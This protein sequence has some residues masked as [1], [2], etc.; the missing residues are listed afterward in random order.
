MNENNKDVET[1]YTNEKLNLFFD[2][3]IDEVSMAKHIRRINYI[4][5]LT[6]IRE[7]ET[8]NPMNKDWLD[9]GFYWLN[10]LAEVLDPNLDID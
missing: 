3:T 2:K 6:T 4:L 5:A 10:E 9:N 7:D 1:G 8:K